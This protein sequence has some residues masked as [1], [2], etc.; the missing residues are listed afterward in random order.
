MSFLDADAPWDTPHPYTI[1][2]LESS[3]GNVVYS[4]GKLD[5]T[6]TS[7]PVTLYVGK[8]DVP[9]IK[10]PWMKGTI[11]VTDNKS[12]GSGGSN[13][14]IIGGFYTPTNQVANNLDNDG[15]SHPGWLGYYTNEFPKNGFF[16]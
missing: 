10:Y 15:G 9:D 12:N 7:R 4:T 5:Y 8:Y 6:N 2:I 3:S 16:S 13:N 1:N 14:L 11:T